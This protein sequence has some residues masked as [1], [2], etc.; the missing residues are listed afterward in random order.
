MISFNIY[1][2]KGESVGSYDLKANIFGIKMNPALVHQAIRAQMANA[3]PT[4]AHTKIR[5]EVQGGGRKPWKQKGTGRARQGSIRAP[6]WKGGGIVFGPRSDRNYTQKINKKMKHQALLMSLTDKALNKRLIILDKIEVAFPPKTKIM[7]NLIQN[8]ITNGCI[9]NKLSKVLLTLSPREDYIIKA[10]QNLP[11]VKTCVIDRLNL[12]AI[13][14]SKYLML[15]LE[16][17]KALEIKLQGKST[18]S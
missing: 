14:K 16:A 1:N 3:R 13:L 7:A 12:G 17:L 2:Q 9:D 18:N 4:V 11:N 5:S 6:Q 10:S 8:F 15:P